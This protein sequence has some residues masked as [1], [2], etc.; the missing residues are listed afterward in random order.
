[1]KNINKLNEAIQ[2]KKKTPS[3]N[4][5]YNVKAGDAG[6]YDLR[7]KLIY[8]RYPMYFLHDVQLTT[9]DGKSAQIDFI[10]VTRCI[11][12]VIECK[13]FGFHVKVDS[14]GQFIDMDRNKS[15]QSP[16]EQN[17]EHIDVLT[18]M[19]PKY[20]DRFF[21]II[22]FSNTSRILDRS[23]TPDKLKK[24]I[25]KIDELIPTLERINEEN[26]RTGFLF[27]K[28]LD[29]LSD[30]EMKR[31]AD[32]FLAHHKEK[33]MP[34]EKKTAP[35]K[36]N[37]GY[38]CPNCKKEVVKG[39]YSFRCT[40][41]KMILNK[42]YGHELSEKQVVW[43][44]KNPGKALN[45]NIGG[46]EKVVYAEAVTNNG[47]IQWKTINK[48]AP[49]EKKPVSTVPKNTNNGYICP[50]C[51]GKVCKRQNGSYQCT[52]GC[53]MQISSIYGQK[54]SEKQIICLLT[55][56]RESLKI[57]INGTERI[58]YAEAEKDSKGF[59]HWK[60]VNK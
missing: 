6:E 28:G 15:F 30:S 27:R 54:L 40:S 20:A 34:A 31:Y 18:R 50:N 33:I 39:Q 8:S 56:F 35:K 57:T 25:V 2:I 46:T 24:H 17:R 32:D 41:C 44:L 29:E 16:L 5:D 42:I 36:T 60:V 49:T 52:A 4:P 59:I 58:V 13:N 19:F 37:G 10:A 51:G 14:E 12:F 48:P 26:K 1:M 11:I 7:D 23:N 9:A 45:M 38:I 47:Y 53:N 3:V 21:P 43:L 55:K 22:V